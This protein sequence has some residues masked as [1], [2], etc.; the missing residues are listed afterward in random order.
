MRKVTVY[1]TIRECVEIEVPD[2]LTGDA[3]EEYI[4]AERCATDNKREFIDTT[5]VSWEFSE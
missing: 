5:E 1:E 2:D 3:L 4:E